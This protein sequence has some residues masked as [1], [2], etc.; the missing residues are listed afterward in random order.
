MERMSRESHAILMVDDDARDRRI[1]THALESAGI[2]VTSV[3]NRAGAI[4]MLGEHGAYNLAILDVHLP[5]A[6]GVELCHELSAQYEMP[7]I[8][9]TAASDERDAVHALDSGADDYVR[10]PFSARELIARVRSVL[11]RT[12][13]HEDAL[14]VRLTVGRLTLDAHSYRALVD[15][16]PLPLTPT[17]YRLLSHLAQ[18]AG[19]VMERNELLEYVW[20]PGYQGEHH[21]LHVT[22]SRLRQ[23]L[24]RHESSGLIKTT[25]GIGYEF[26]AAGAPA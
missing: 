11:R 21:M 1:V 20:G 6:N 24:G 26:L 2:E 13:R 10:K 9:L 17:E 22:V 25:P 8:M 7:I 3:S 19:R 12:H 15:D 23:K 14:D 4:E 5:D 16:E 18:N